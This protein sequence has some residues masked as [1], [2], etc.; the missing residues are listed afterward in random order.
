MS[1]TTTTEHVLVVPTHL[2]HSIG[3]FQGF[4]SR[5]E[6]YIEQ[7]LDP[8]NTSY[9]RRDLMEDDPTFKQ[10]IPYCIFRSTSPDNV[11][12]LFQYTRG[13]KQGEK[14]L[15][16]KRSI[17]IGGHISSLDQGETSPYE[18]GMQR[19]LDEEVFVDT[20]FESA[21]VGL[22]NDDENDVG[23]VHLGIVHIFDVSEP[24]V[25]SRETEIED[26]GFLPLSNIFE[27]IEHYETWSQICLKSLF[28]L[29]S[30]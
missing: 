2:F 9:R 26:A 15:H 12:S 1:T 7:L 11:V 18:V 8:K 25:Q 20:T 29:S 24:K 27:N 14:R 6:P 17:G 10:L 5:F 23:K 16:A 30:P 21:C 4:E 19:E 13:K 22:I 28:K 3:H